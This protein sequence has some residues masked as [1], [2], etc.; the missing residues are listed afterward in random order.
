MSH[1]D[2]VISLPRDFKSIASSSNTKFAAVENKK[3]LIMVY[4]FILKLSIHPMVI[5]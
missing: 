4:N 3:N 5:R 2:K 1:G